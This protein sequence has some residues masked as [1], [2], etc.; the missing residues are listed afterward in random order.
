MN[1]QEKSPFVGAWEVA[2]DWGKGDGEERLIVSVHPD[3]TGTIEHG[4]QGWTSE[5]GNVEAQGDDL[6]FSFLYGGAGGYEM[7]FAGT[8]VANEIQGELSIF[9]NSTAVVGVPFSAEEKS[10]VAG[11]WKLTS[12]WGK[13]ELGEHMLTI[14]PDLTGTVKHL[15]DGWRPAL[16][17]VESTGDGLSFSFYWEE[18]EEYETEFAGT[19][20]DDEINGKFTIFG[21]TAVVVG[22]PMSAA[23]VARAAARVSYADRYEARSFTSS[24]GDTLPYRLFV[25]AEYD[26][27]KEYP[28]VLFHHGGGGT[29]NDNRRNLE[30][31]LVKEWILPEVQAKNPSFIVVP[32]IPGKESKTSESLE[33]ALDAMKLRIRTIHEILD[34][35]EEEFS[36]DRSREYVTG[37]SFGGECTWMSMIER[38]DR[39]AA[40]VPICATSLLAEMDAA[41]R[42]ERF[43]RLP[44]WI[45]HGDADQVVPVETSRKI[46]KALR[47]AGGDPKYTEYPDVDHNSWDLAYRDPELIE[48]LFAQS[49]GPDQQ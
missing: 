18:N 42:G 40:A 46:V 32:Q 33:A 43:A 17:N 10:P 15:E 27:Q 19:I 25:P 21:A 39:F 34:S 1:T 12:D 6:T 3:L 35:L 24:E 5:L 37:L 47:D 16:R 26:P 8:V 41:D 30:G 7:A 36:I 14:K 9:G 13:G 28:L 31:A 11:T 20:V 38:P 45:F 4:E 44:I 48:W 22:T 29:G 2:V 23:D 49:R